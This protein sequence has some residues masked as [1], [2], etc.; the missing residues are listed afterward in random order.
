MVLLRFNRWVAIH[1]KK[2]HQ[3]ALSYISGGS[4]CSALII[5]PY[6]PSAETDAHIQSWKGRVRLLPIPLLHPGSY[7][8]CCREDPRWLSPS[9]PSFHFFF[10]PPPT[11]P[12]PSRP[13]LGQTERR[14]CLLRPRLYR[15][16][17][18][19]IVENLLHAEGP[20]CVC[21]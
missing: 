21:L 4:D 3:P 15:L 13:R 17:S 8:H 12:I 7:I 20:A 9:L 11:P 5:Q 1:E 19:Y 14:C 6:F 16:G 10:L 18:V 2:L